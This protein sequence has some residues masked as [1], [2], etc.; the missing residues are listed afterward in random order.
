[1][2]Y[3]VQPPPIPAANFFLIF[4]LSERLRIRP[5]GIDQLTST[6]NEAAR[7]ANIH[8]RVAFESIRDTKTQ[9]SVL[10]HIGSPW[11]RFPRAMLKIIPQ[12]RTVDI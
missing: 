1:V 2:S 5:V 4:E 11:D 7:Q 9:R 3:P 10:E 12:S 8:T 6:V